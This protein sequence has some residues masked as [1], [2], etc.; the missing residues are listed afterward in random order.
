M[1]LFFV[2][3]T[4]AA[5]RLDDSGWPQWRGPTRDGHAVGTSWP[6]SLQEDRLVQDWR[7][8]LGPSYSGPI[9]V[10]D[11]VVTTE[12]RG[13]K[14]EVATAYNLKTGEQIW[15]VQWPGSTKV[16]FFAASN[17]SWIRA[18]P[19]ADNKAI[20]V[21]G[22]Q[23]VLVAID[24][25]SGKQRW[26][27]DFPKDYG[28]EPPKF[29]AASSPMLDGDY[30]YAQVGGGFTKIDKQTGE[31]LWTVAEGGGGMSGG[32]F[33]SPSIATINGQRIAMVQTREELKG[34]TLETGSELWSQPIQA[35]RGMNILTPVSYKN[36]VFTSAH[37]G[38]SQ[39]WQ[40]GSGAST[41]LQ[42][43]WKDKSQAYMSSPVIVGDHLYLH[44]KNQ[45]MQCLNLETGVE[46]WR[47]RPYGKYQSMVV[48]GENILALDASGELILFEATPD[49]LNII[50]SRKIS[51]A[52]TWAH[53]AVCGGKLVIRELNA[54]A[55]YSWR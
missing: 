6:T 23:D 3:S 34:I 11:R 31:V 28:T 40:I 46:A 12:T 4:L 49:S 43:V 8:E 19:V 2:T 48:L 25:V 26:R 20:Y 37:S 1:T 52:E 15:Q 18:T 33:S 27:I 55:V 29:G 53:L 9:I 24:L 32:A 54:L 47:S 41:Q 39:L 35:F 44:L 17:G 50:D 22:I 13:E 16:P 5:D 36:K 42:E 10:E 30:I 38:R 21:V 14:T 45:R 51:D 7:V